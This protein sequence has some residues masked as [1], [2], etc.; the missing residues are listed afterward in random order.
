MIGGRNT[1]NSIE[2]MS[3]INDSNSVTNNVKKFVTVE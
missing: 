3:H 2:E 1:N